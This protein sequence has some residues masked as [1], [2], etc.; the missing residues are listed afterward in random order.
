MKS[1]ARIVLIAAFD[2]LYPRLILEQ[3]NS[4][5]LSPESI[6]L[7]SPAA[8]TLFNL[9]SLGRIRARHGW[10]E[11]LS[12]IADR[13]LGASLQPLFKPPPSLFDSANRLGIRIHL[14]DVLNSGRFIAD[15]MEVDCDV[16]ILGGCGIV[17]QWVCTIPR[18][19]SINAHPAILP[20]ARG[21]DVVD[22][23]LLNGHEFGVTT[24]LVE[25]KVD[26]GDILRQIRAE[27]ERGEPLY[28]FRNRLLHLQAEAAAVA[29]KQFLQGTAKRVP[30]DLSQSVLYHA[31][32]RAH[33]R[34]AGKIY[35]ERY[36]S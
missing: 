4:I 22:W 9:K 1:R 19:G 29:T 2:N 8:R 20:G 6:F 23:S 18:L 25:P 10:I 11:V 17:N 14:Y 15:L 28:A 31:M 36:L 35:A 33:R 21:V 13:R 34:Q 26:A 7:G 16:A 32:D 3:L 12:R 24:H 5:G 30:H 27:P